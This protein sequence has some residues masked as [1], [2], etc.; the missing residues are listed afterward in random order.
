MEK[1]CIFSSIQYRIEGGEWQPVE[2]RANS[3]AN[4]L[5][6]IS[7]NVFELNEVKKIEV[8]W[9]N[10][11]N[12]ALKAQFML[13][14]TSEFTAEH[15][16]IPCVMY[17]GN[18]W[19][20][21]G[22]PKGYEKN[23]K[24]WVFSSFR[25]GIPACTLSENDKEVLAFFAGDDSPDSLRASCSLYPMADGRV[26]HRILY[27][28]LE[29]PLTYSQRDMYSGPYE[30]QLALEP[31]EVFRS[32]VYVWHGVPQWKNF[33][34]AGLQ[35]VAMEL[36]HPAHS[37]VPAPEEVWR[38][39]ILY[40]RQLAQPYHG[41]RLFAIGFHW[42]EA[43]GR[44]VPVPHFECGWCGQN[45]LYAR[46]L[47]LNFQKDGDPSD[48]QLAEEVLRRWSEEAVLPSGLMRV[49]FEKTDSTPV[50][51]CNLGFAM[52]EFAKCD[53]LLRSMGR[54][55]ESCLKAARGIAEFFRSRFSEEYGF[56]HSWNPL[57]GE[58]LQHGGT[59]G[60]FLVQGFV[61][62]YRTTR[63]EW[64][65]ELAEKA[66]NFYTHRDLDRCM[67]A[68]GALDTSC[69]D[70]ET[71]GSLL[72]GALMLYEDTGKAEMLTIAQKAAYYFCSWMFYYNAPFRPESDFVR[73]GYQPA[74]GTSVSA[75]H[76]HLDCWGAL[77]VPWLWKLAD[78]TGD[79]RWKER[80]RLIWHNV[81]SCITNE[82]TPLIHGKQRLV[83]S[84]NEGF[85]HC[86]WGF[87]GE[88]EPGQLNDWLVA[89][90]GAYRMNALSSMKDPRDL[91]WPQ[92]LSSS[93][94]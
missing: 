80:A 57:T 11:S 63:E 81:A 48:L 21:G 33:G 73:Y 6:D 25:T 54:P 10:V 64:L 29:E 52:A 41:G 40:A 68:A 77:L 69:I 67:T 31:G 72:V 61:E 22:E 36:L 82:R 59:A 14:V 20:S 4:E 23:G 55:M 49:H 3:A 94:Q 75:Q 2:L 19:G 12:Q 26:R 43:A 27:P 13:E 18:D 44:F 76:H 66:L 46:M 93:L 5:L 45:L 85:Y 15:T 71:S 74:G 24:P 30:E 53:R 62:V 47:L 92:E 39:G 70:K 90:M 50:D 9:K 16:V 78:Y 37:A 79:S 1:A 89:W 65:V 38:L 91:Y 84:Q 88:G 51:T 8:N 87:E 83:G 60:A 7:W 32:V 56:G 35:N 28:T 17:N 42:D 34:I 58:L 86:R